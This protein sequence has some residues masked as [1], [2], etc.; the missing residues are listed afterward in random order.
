VLLVVSQP[1]YAQFELDPIVKDRNPLG[2]SDWRYTTGG[3]TDIEYRWRMGMCLAPGCLKDVEFRNNTKTI[4]FD[5][6]IWSE[7]MVDKGAEVKNTGTISVLSESTSK[8]VAGAG[9]NLKRVIITINKSAASDIATA[10]QATYE[11]GETVRLADKDFTQAIS[12]IRSAVA[13]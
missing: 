10:A 2:W 9:G 1:A 6:T 12:N 13:K 11:L 7:G 4:R 8:A 3:G 5:Y